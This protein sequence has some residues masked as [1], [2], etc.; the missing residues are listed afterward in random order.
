MPKEMNMIKTNIMAI[1]FYTL[2]IFALGC[3]YIMLNLDF[4]TDERVS[5]KAVAVFM[6]AAVCWILGSIILHYA[7]RT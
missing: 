4:R 6:F 2:G 5:R 7:W 3:D 1:I